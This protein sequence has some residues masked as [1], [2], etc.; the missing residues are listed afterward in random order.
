MIKK[1]Y[2]FQ[3]QHEG[4]NSQ[5]LSLDF[6]HFFCL[7]KITKINFKLIKNLKKNERHFIFLIKNLYVFK[8]YHI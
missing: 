7:K 1:L 5:N 8:S 4:D 2:G 6:L 3:I